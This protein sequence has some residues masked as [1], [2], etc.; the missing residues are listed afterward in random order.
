[1]FDMSQAECRNVDPE[2]FFSNEND[3]YLYGEEARAVCR[4]C[5][6]QTACLQF[7]LDNDEQGIWGGTDER[8]RKAIRFN[9]PLP[10]RS[11]STSSEYRRR[12]YAEKKLRAEKAAVLLK[13]NKDRQGLSPEKAGRI[14]DALIAGGD[15]VPDRTR[16]IAEFRLNNPEMSLTELAEANM[17]GLNREQIAGI[18]GRLVRGGK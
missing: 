1:M 7:A 15:S 11:G 13:Y 2:M 5:P 6:L 18:L 10:R 8:D 9:R 12:M 14:V 16:A 3:I 4:I 17:L